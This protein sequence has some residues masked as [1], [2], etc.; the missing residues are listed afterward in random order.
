MEFLEQ[1]PEASIVIEGHTD[2]V[3]SEQYNKQLSEDR[4]NAVKTYLVSEGI[5]ETRISTLGKGEESPVANNDTP[6]GRAMN[7]RIEITIPD[8]VETER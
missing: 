5:S 6:D 8:V 7:R 3:G 1:H 2:N 4:A